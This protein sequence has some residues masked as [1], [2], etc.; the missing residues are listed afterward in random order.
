MEEKKLRVKELEDKRICCERVHYR[1]SRENNGV[2]DNGGKLRSSSGD[3]WQLVR[4]FRLCKV[5]QMGLEV[6]GGSICCSGVRRIR[7]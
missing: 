5:R 6:V 3:P 4:G 2:M 7:I 1:L